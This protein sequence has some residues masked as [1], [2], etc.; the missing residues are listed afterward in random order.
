M[1]STYRA[2]QI[3]APGRLELVELTIPIPGAGE[4]LLA[5][6]ACGICGADRNDIENADPAKRRVPGHEV[7]GRIVARG[8]GVP[9][10]WEVGQRV[11]VGRFGGH[12]Q[13]CRDCRRGQFH[14]CR[15]QPVMGASCDGGYA[16]R[17]IARATGLVAIPNELSSEEA[18]PILCA[19]I[20]TFNGLK[21]SGAEPGDTVAIFGVG[22]LGHMAVQYANRMGLR[23]VAI[24]RGQDIVSD[25]LNLGAHRYID[26]THE[27]AGKVLTE[28]G[29][30][31]AILSTVT[32]ADA[33]SAILPGLAPE[34]RLVVLGI[35]KDPLTV[36]MGPLVAGE[37]TVLGSIT[38]SP[39]ENE[40]TLGFSVLTGARP[41]IETL[42]LER[43]N[44]A[45]QRM[46]SGQAKFR[47]VL[48][49][50]G[51]NDAT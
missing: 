10:M 19:G 15:Q 11:G 1:V 25:V 33:V 6:E 47:V 50:T 32:N 18:A 51:R 22:G 14:L 5:V 49:M 21:A 20:A 40:R 3:A 31:T 45:Y 46:L 29:G 2:M 48:T 28:M 12:C 23:V 7:I 27:D 16:E 36:T 38:G 44:E 39:Y 13:E 34:G 42:P 35:G 41:L 37:R 17:M 9:S 26:T 30:A 24:G 4:V 43:A 8:Q